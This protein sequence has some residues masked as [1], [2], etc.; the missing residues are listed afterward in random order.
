MRTGPRFGP[1]VGARLSPGFSTGL[2]ALVAAGMIAAPAGAQS[3][4]AGEPSFPKDTGKPGK[5]KPG[6]EK[7]PAKE[8]VPGDTTDARGGLIDLRP[9]FER[10]GRIRYVMRIK[11]ENDVAVPSLL[12]GLDEP[13][14]APV[15]PPVGPG[16]P[17]PP[18]QPGEPASKEKRQKQVIAQEIGFALRTIE[19]TP[20]DGSTVEMVYERVKID[21]DTGD[22]HQSWDSEQKRDPARPGADQ[23]ND[24]DL[25]EPIFR[26]LVGTKLTIRLDAA[27]N[28]KSVEGGG[29][30][31]L[32]GMQGQAG[33]PIDPKSIGSLFGPITSGKSG[34]GQYRVGE[35]WSNVDDVNTGPMGSFRMRTEHTLRSARG[36][37]A[38]VLVNGRIEPG[39]AAGTPGS[40]FQLKDARYQGKY[41]W[42]YAR[43]Q[44]K[45]METEQETSIDSTSPGSK[46]DGSSMKSKTLVRVERL[47]GDRKPR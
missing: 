37:E 13:E 4:G 32:P 29:E 2:L 15:R 31:A 42:D 6:P 40:P 12:P 45:S 26:G 44:L 23:R 27:G 24:S 47:T 7:S 35:R 22:Y 39:S 41:V 11:S 1:H 20:E 5:E 43:G 10:G 33:I 21:I 17:T 38:E 34:K 30:L 19:T 8:R 3:P 14:R 28:I 9:R 25:L 36:G 46:T 16:Q 18:G